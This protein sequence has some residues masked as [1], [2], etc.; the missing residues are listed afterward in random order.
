MPGPLIIHKKLAKTLLHCIILILAVNTFHLFIV[1]GNIMRNHLK[2]I[3]VVF[4]FTGIANATGEGWITNMTRARRVAAAEKK[5]ILI[6]ITGTDWCGYCIK[7]EEKVFSH[8]LFIQQAP[9]HFVL[10]E[11]D[12]PHGEEKKAGQSAKLKK[13]NSDWKKK[14]KVSGYPTI[15]LLDHRGKPY[16]RKIGYLRETPEKYLQILESLRNI[17]IE[18]DKYFILARR[19]KDIS[20]TAELLDKSL[21]CMET[22][23]IVNHYSDLVKKMIELASGDDQGLK[24]KYQNLS[25]IVDLKKQIKSAKRKADLTVLKIL[26]DKQL[27]LV[28]GKGRDGQEALF[29]L[30][31]ALRTSDPESA[32]KTFK[33]ALA[34]DPGGVLT[35]RIESLIR[36]SYAQLK[37]K[38]QARKERK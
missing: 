36:K 23:I 14:L 6:N 11:M 1:L 26:V 19:T 15:F 28:G 27:K 5:D 4:L 24:T 37:N 17:R 10:V 35:E 29:E 2:L 25:K 7:L 18:R 12:F 21:S 31:Y 20:Q 22:E 30:G 33:D 16:A 3:S 8:D 38:T 32:I 13:Q 9:K 34:A